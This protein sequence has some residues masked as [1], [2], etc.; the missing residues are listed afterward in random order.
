VGVLV[1]VTPVMTP[2]VGYLFR[3]ADVSARFGQ[4]L[5]EFLALFFLFIPVLVVVLIFIL[6]VE[7]RSF[8]RSRA[9][10]VMVVWMARRAV[11]SPVGLRRG[12][13]AALMGSADFVMTTA[14]GLHGGG[15]CSNITHSIHMR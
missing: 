12:A 11:L 4:E 13:A 2:T 7:I 14:S 10:V 6:A 8:S 9:S 15:R 5:L 3:D 1:F